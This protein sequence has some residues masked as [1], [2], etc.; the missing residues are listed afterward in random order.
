MLDSSIALSQ[1]GYTS[2]ANYNDMKSHDKSLWVGNSAGRIYYHDNS[3][4]SVAM[5]AEKFNGTKVIYELKDKKT[6]PLS[7][8]IRPLP[9]EAGST[10]T[11]VNEHNLDMPSVIK[12]KK[13]V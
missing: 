5:A 6:I 13:E 12:Y 2:Y 7:D 8:F 4:T 10:L 9:V 3:I 1:L 11:L